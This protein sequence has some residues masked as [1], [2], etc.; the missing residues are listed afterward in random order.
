MRV[1]VVTNRLLQG[2][3]AAMHDTAQLCGRESSKPPLDHIDPR[4]VGRGEVP[5]VAGT[6]RE[7]PANE[8]GLVRPVVVQDQVNVQVSRHVGINQVEE[9]PKFDG[10]MSSAGLAQNLP[11]LHVCLLYTSDAADE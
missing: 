2:R 6:L 3:D 1:D 5:L 4:P 10:P 11:G 9:L 8:C 7:P